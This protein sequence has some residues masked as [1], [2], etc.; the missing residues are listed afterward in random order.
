MIFGIGLPFTG[1]MNLSLALS[2]LGYRTVHFPRDP[3]TLEQLQISAG[4]LDLMHHFHAA[5]DL[6]LAVHY[7]KLDQLYPGSKFILTVRDEAKCR[8]VWENYFSQPP[9]SLDEIGCRQIIFD[10]LRLDVQQAADALSWHVREV[11][12]YFQDSASSRLLVMDIHQGDGWEKLCPFLEI[13]APAAP[14]PH[15]LAHG[16]R[17]LLLPQAKHMQ[18]YRELL[19]HICRALSP[20]RIL[21]WGPGE[22]T[23]IMA[24]ECPVPLP[25]MLARF[26]D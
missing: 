1:T 21:E 16:D 2:Y 23:R 11:L 7:K 5:V 6:P 12:Y 19:I 3:R 13:P 8:A 15:P 14:F 20:K 26:L 10:L 24:K 9:V 4:G 22:S 18:S 25:I 17:Y